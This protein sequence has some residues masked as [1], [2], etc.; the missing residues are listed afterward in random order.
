MP[1][2]VALLRGVNLGP[3]KRMKMEK[4]RVS[5][6]AL[7]FEQIQT[8]IQSGNVIFK[9]GKASPAALCRKIE[10]RI[11]ADFGFPAAVI[12][13]TRDELGESIESNPFCKR[14]GIDLKYLH[15][16]FLADAPEPSALEELKGL[17]VS[18]DESICVGREIFLHL[19]NGM[20]RSSLTNNP[21]ERRLL[22]AATTRN[23]NT[24]NQIYE[25]CRA[26]R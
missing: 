2:Y 20:A 23:W 18:P 4:L 21:I 1:I 12:V 26:C 17:T 14:R 16:T 19:P 24:V 25:M 15:V 9:A 8:Y 7:G 13:R 22:K 10:D 3:H 5:V 6:G 11:V